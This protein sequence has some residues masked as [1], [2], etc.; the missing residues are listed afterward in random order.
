[1][2]V[3]ASNVGCRAP[4][5]TRI[6]STRPRWP[7]DW[8]ASP[9]HIEPPP[10]L[11]G[12]IYQAADVAAVPGTLGEATDLFERSVFACAA[13]GDAVVDYYTEVLP[14]RI[15]SLRH[16]DSAVGTSTVLRTYLMGRHDW[17]MTRPTIG[18]T[19]YGRNEHG[20]F[21]LPGEY[22][23]AVRRTGASAVLLPP[24]EHVAHEWLTR[25]DG[26]ILAGGGD[27]DPYHYNGSGHATLYMVDEERD[28]TEI[29]LA[30]RALSTEMPILAICRGAQVLNIAMGGT[31]HAHLPDVVGESVAH[32]VPP[33][34]PTT[35][36]ITVSTGSRLAGILGDTTF[37][38]ASWHHQAIDRVA[39][40]LDVVGRAPERHGRGGR[41]A[42]SPMV[43]G[44]PVAS[45]A[46]GSHRRHPA[47]PVRCARDG[48]R[49]GERFVTDRSTR[50]S[51]MRLANKV[52]LITGAASGIGRETAVPIR[53]RPAKGNRLSID[54][55]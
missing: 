1:M 40:L 38:A 7:P 14:D 31:L 50:R 53:L 47:A 33:R 41:D 27:I 4:T 46:D 25:I 9:N 13:F 28:R 3:R 19:T 39:P 37:N 36:V 21:T 54:T 52:A 12:N 15:G 34:Q 10:H 2:K 45:G 23:D 24:G 51:S 29:D 22:V 11:D 18:I 35:H 17:T 43:R 20:H 42:R 44:C 48:L 26:L 6:S 32:R 8:T 30:A 5:A 16:L 55:M 49:R